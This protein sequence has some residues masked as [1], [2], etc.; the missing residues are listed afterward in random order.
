MGILRESFSLPGISISAFRRSLGNQ[1]LWTVDDG[2]PSEARFEVGVLSLRGL[3]GKDL[4]GVGV[5][6]GFGWDRYSG[7]ATVA[8]TDPEGGNSDGNG[9]GDLRSDRRIYFAGAS[10]TF[11]AL[12]ISGEVGWAEGFDTTLPLPR[13]GGFNPASGSHFGSLAL[14]L[15]F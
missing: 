7:D 14:R 13:Q 5:F 15:T 10:R 4:W 2:D 3:V 12:Q 8:V 11:L 9:V 6:G 1:R